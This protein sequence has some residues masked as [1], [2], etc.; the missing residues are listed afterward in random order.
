VGLGLAV[1]KGF[2][3]VMGGMLDAEQ[4][5]GGGLTLVIRLP[6]STGAVEL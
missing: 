1:A 5:P 2:T 4:T 6:I 3:E